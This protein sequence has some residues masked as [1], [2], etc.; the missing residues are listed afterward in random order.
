M[1]KKIKTSSKQS[2]ILGKNQSTGIIELAQVYAK[3]RVWPR[4]FLREESLSKYFH[5][6]R[7][8][9]FL[10]YQKEFQSFYNEYNRSFD[11]KNNTRVP[12]V[13]MPYWGA[14]AWGSD[15]RIFLLTNE[16]DVKL[17]LTPPI[18]I[19]MIEFDDPESAYNFA[20]QLNS[21]DIR[22]GGKGYPMRSFSTTW[23]LMHV[24]FGEAFFKYAKSIMFC[25]DY[26]KNLDSE[27]ENVDLFVNEFGVVRP[28]I[29]ICC[30]IRLFETVLKILHLRK[31]R[32]PVLDKKSNCL[33]V[34]VSNPAFGW[35]S[36]LFPSEKYRLIL[37]KRL[38]EMFPEV[39]QGP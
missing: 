9:P 16:A 13:C 8:E 38:G 2:P 7:Q 1:K 37:N 24:L 25:S 32:S 23:F 28:A 31:T 11:A 15:K 20:Q 4:F 22:M 21:V 18:Y 14:K 12:F 27:K 5:K 39:G 35:D 3:Y 17:A 26:V 33:I 29:L 34:P 10:K 36:K 30:G 19:P 6:N